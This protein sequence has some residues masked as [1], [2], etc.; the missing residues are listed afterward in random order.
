MFYNY[1]EIS[2]QNLYKEYLQIAGALSNL[3]SDSN[4]PYLYYRAAENIFCM[5]FAAINHSRAD[6]SIDAS[7]ESIGIGLKT[8]LHGNGKTFQKVAEFNAIRNQLDGKSTD[9]IIEIIVNARNARIDASNEIYGLDQTIYHCVTRDIGKFFLYELPMQTIQIPDIHGIVTDKNTIKFSDSIHSYSFN[10][11]KSTLYKQFSFSNTP[12]ETIDIEILDNPLAMLKN[13]LFQKSNQA[14]IQQQ[15]DLFASSPQ[16]Q[17]SIYLPLY[18]PSSD[19][20]EPAKKSGLNQWNAEGRVR[21]PDEVYIPVPAWIHQKFSGF[22]PDSKDELFELHLPNRQVLS[23]KM[24]QAGL[25]GL[26]S[27]PNKALGK[28]ILRDILQVPEGHLVTKEILDTVGI[29]SI[30]IE[31]SD[32]LKYKIDFAKTGSFEQFKEQYAD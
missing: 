14:I 27:N 20:G 13:L 23:A 17:E 8:F 24:C 30:Y 6:A 16:H 3:Y 25:K 28:W 29:D 21:H 10:I 9:E 26:M 18:A 4:V 5:A 1:Q 2:F 12:L 11:S 7:K 15:P 19:T 22:F 31:K 32:H